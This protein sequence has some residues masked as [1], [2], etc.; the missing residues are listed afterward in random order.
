MRI[1]GIGSIATRAVGGLPFAMRRLVEL[2]RALVGSPIVLM[3]DEPAAGLESSQRTSLAALLRGL[4]QAS[5]VAI[6]LIE[7]DI[8]FVTA[9]ADSV[10]ALDFGMVIAHGAAGDV[11]ADPAVRAAFLG[12]QA[13]PASGE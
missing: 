5:E 2:G 7:H 8:Q 1:L 12:I 11:L 4:V 10:F 9:V 6:L 13:D 3:L